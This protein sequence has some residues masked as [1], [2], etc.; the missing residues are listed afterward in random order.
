LGF[1]APKSVTEKINLEYGF[2]FYT[3]TQN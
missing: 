1:D 3:F 2:D